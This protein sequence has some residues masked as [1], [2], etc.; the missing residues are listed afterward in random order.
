MID[1]MNGL[2]L[3]QSETTVIWM[4]YATQSPSLPALSILLRGHI[5][6]AIS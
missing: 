2:Y 4:T 5:Q 6:L 1:N 3:Q